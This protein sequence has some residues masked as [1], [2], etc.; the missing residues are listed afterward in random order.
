MEFIEQSIPLIFVIEPKKFGDNRGYFMETY[1][2]DLFEAKVGKVDFVQDN[3][4]RSSYGVLRGMHFQKGE[5][6]QAKLVRVL[7][8]KV[9]DVAV[10]LRRSS[11]TFG[12]YVAVELSDENAR[13]L[14]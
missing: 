6:S 5:F 11:P 10:D 3:E 4:S 7:Q 14:F 8:G 1:R 13:Q 2:Q 9:L 12:K